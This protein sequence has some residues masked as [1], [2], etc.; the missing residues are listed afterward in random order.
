MQLNS[1][2][3]LESVW[4]MYRITGDTAWQEKGWRMITAIINATQIPEGHSAVSDVRM[5]ANATQVEEAVLAAQVPDERPFVAGGPGHRAAAALAESAGAWKAGKHRGGAAAGGEAAAGKGKENKKKEK[6]R[7]R[8]GGVMMDNMESFWI[9]ETL[10]YGYLL[11]TTPDVVSLD[12][13]VLNTEA[14]PFRRPK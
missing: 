4:Y 7:P 13:W 10:K 3:A 2:E 14:H 6:S 11:F 5:D 1:P 12:E 8:P 9:A